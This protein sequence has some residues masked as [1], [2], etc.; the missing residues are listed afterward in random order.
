[1]LIY[2]L[3]TNNKVWEDRYDTD[4]KKYNESLRGTSSQPIAS[5][6]ESNGKTIVFD[7]FF[8]CENFILNKNILVVYHST[9]KMID[10]FD[11]WDWQRFK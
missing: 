2:I 7:T 3:F 9:E 6:V 4:M 1:M 11:T 10:S 5:S 8:V